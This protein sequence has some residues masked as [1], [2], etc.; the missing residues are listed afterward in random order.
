MKNM[1]NEKTCRICGKDNASFTE[2]GRVING[3]NLYQCVDCKTILVFP[4]ESDNANSSVYDELFATGEYEMHRKQFELL[5]Q[6]RMPLE[7]HRQQMLRRVEKM[8]HGRNLVEIGGGTGSFGMFCQKKEWK[9]ADYDISSVAVEYAKKLGLEAHVIEDPNRPQL[10]SADV[11]ALWEV[12]EH[13]WNVREYLENIKKALGPSGL[14]I[15]STPNYWRRGYRLSDTW[16]RVSSPPVHVNFFTEESL[17]LSLKSA[18]FS[19]VKIIQ[20][21][22]YRPSS[23]LLNILYTLQIAFGIEPTKTLFAI[24]GQK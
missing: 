23:N 10:P 20:P 17:A 12:I 19:S 6:G 11:I 13:I 15:L 1:A 7:F 9:Y 18:G 21:K 24:A 3:Y 2:T 4:V 14:L 22:F 16:G 8:T 5:S